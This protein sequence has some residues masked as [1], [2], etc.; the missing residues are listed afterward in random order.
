[1]TMSDAVTLERLV[2]LSRLNR[3]LYLDPKS[4]LTQGFFF[5]QGEET[6]EASSEGDDDDDESQ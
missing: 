1:M 6:G 5:R 2:A 4:N 3:M